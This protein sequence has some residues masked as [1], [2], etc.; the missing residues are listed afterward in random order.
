[1][2]IVCSHRLVLGRKAHIEV[3]HGFSENVGASKFSRSD[4]ENNASGPVNRGG[5]A[6]LLLLRTLLAI[7]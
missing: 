4:A 3:W 5:M 7:S 1:M 2:G 6:D